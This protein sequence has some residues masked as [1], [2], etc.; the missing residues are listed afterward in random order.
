MPP[1]RDVGGFFERDDVSESG[2]GESDFRAEV[3]A[4]RLVA[5]SYEEP[6]F[7]LNLTAYAL[8]F[9]LPKALRR[10]R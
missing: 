5:T 4:R 10:A 2:V 6:I 1:T 8:R 9:Q 7:V 3:T